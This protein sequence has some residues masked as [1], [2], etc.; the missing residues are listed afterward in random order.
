MDF[1]NNI[2]IRDATLDDV[3]SIYNLTKP[4]VD[5]GELLPRS[6]DDIADHIRNFIVA[7]INRKVVG[8]MAIK[9]YSKEMTEFRTLVV[10]ESFQG[11]GIGK[12]LVEKGL[13]IVKNMGVKRVFVLTR[14]EGFFKKVG[15]ETVKKEIFPEKVWFDCMLCPRLN[16]CDEIAMVKKL[17]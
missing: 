2:I 4:Y 16:N 5:K 15:F 13:E 3:E 11:K 7:D 1:E 10:D 14:S 8:C 9:F 6:K 17:I 12:M